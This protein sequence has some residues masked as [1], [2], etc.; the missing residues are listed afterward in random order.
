[1]NILYVSQN[2]LQ[3]GICLKFPDTFISATKKTI[4]TTAVSCKFNNITCSL[5]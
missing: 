3:L 1:M 4:N 2:N 5:F